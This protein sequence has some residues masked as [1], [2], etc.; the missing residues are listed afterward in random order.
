MR[1]VSGINRKA[2][3]MKHHLALAAALAA[4]AVGSASAQ[5]AEFKCPAV[6]TEFGYRSAMGDSVATAAGQDGN[7][8]LLKRA[9]GGKTEQVRMHWGLIGSVDAQG[10][11]FAGGIALKSL[12]PL[13]VGNKT[14]NA[15]TLTGRDGK[16]YSSTVTVT[17]AAYEKV[18]VPAGIFDAFRVEEN[19]AGEAAR[20]IHWW[21]PA[22]GQSIKESFPDWRD[23]GK[24]VVIELTAVKAAA[25]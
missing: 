25:R 4:C 18:T 15:I 10:E 23:P 16:T 21:A 7:V 8:C 12:W 6:G 24:T 19:K 1:L 17:V 13:K 22:L 14:T 11:A 20:N 9:G 5:T 3:S 2:T